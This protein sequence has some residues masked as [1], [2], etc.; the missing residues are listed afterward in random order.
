MIFE[1]G[2]QSVVIA[3]GKELIELE[4]DDYTIVEATGYCVDEGAIKEMTN[5]N[6]VTVV[7]GAVGV[8]NMFTAIQ[9]AHDSVLV[10]CA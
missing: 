3:R 9:D 5:R 1:T 4:V 6:N 10:I 2:E 8:G 7:D